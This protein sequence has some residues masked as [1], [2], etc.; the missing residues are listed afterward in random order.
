MT[1]NAELL[2][3]IVHL[4]QDNAL[5]RQRVRELEEKPVM[6][7][8]PADTTWEMPSAAGVFAKC[9]GG[10]YGSA[11]GG[12]VVIPADKTGQFAVGAATKETRNDHNR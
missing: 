1:T 3:T 12:M 5:L 4:A 2:E 7:R 11:G 6:L 10:G 9:G 8:V